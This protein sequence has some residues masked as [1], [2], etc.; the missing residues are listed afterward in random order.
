M[1]RRRNRGLSEIVDIQK[2]ELDKFSDIT[3]QVDDINVDSNFKAN[4]AGL[5]EDYYHL[6]ET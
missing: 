1:L 3:T 4:I 5:A 2:N 6:T